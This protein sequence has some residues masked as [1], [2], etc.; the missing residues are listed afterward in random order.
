VPCLP[1]LVCAGNNNLPV[2]TSAILDTRNATSLFYGVLP[3]GASSAKWWVPCPTV[4]DSQQ[5]QRHQALRHSIEMSSC[6]RVSSVWSPQSTHV[7]QLSSSSFPALMLVNTTNT[8]LITAVINVDQNMFSNYMHDSAAKTPVMQLLTNTD[9]GNAV[10]LVSLEMDTV[11]VVLGFTE[12]LVSKQELLF[13]LHEINQS[14]GVAHST[15]VPLLW[16][17]AV[18]R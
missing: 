3:V 2:S 9:L 4:R 1:N 5:G 17:C 14:T 13:A 8:S 11:H 10:W 16:A 18:R 6:F 7:P 12:T 15:L